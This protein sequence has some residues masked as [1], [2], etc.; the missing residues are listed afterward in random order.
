[1]VTCQTKFYKKQIF[2]KQNF[3]QSSIIHIKIYI[4][5]IVLH[6]KLKNPITHDQLFN[7]T[8]TTTIE[9]YKEVKITTKKNI[10]KLK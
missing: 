2:P 3:A 8:T 10:K 6:I 7:L 9:S 5:P 4:H 1:M